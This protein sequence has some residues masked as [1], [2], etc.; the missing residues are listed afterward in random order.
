MPQI[1]NVTCRADP[2]P[3]SVAI[4]VACDLAFGPT[5][6]G[7]TYVVEIDII[8]DEVSFLCGPNVLY[9]LRFGELALALQRDYM[10]V[11]GAAAGVHIDET[12]IVPRA[13]LDEAPGV[14]WVK[15]LPMPDKDEFHARVRVSQVTEAVSDLQ[16]IY[17]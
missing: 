2:K 8:S 15:G 16:T 5:E 4:S 17:A 7:K 6:H 13:N 1:S 9:T 11:T 12:R 10:I 14:T 3:D